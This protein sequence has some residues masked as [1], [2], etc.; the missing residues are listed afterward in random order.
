MGV[1]ILL[2]LIV[3]L[4]ASVPASAG[5]LVAETQHFRIYSQGSEKQL[6]ADAAVLEDYHQLLE[7]LTQRKFADDAPRLDIYLVR[8]GAALR[9]IVPEIGKQVAGFYHASDAGIAAFAASGS[10]PADWTP[11][12][13]I[14]LHEYAHHFMSQVGSAA[15]PAWYVEGFAEYLMTATFRPDRVEFGNY[16]KG[17][18][19]TLAAM[20]WISME[21]LLTRPPGVNIDAFYAQSWLLT[22]Y[23]FRAEGMAPRLKAYLARVTAGEDPV[24]AFKAEVANDLPGFQS[25]LRAYLNGNN[26]TY[27][28]MK[29]RPPEAARVTV[30]ALP[31]AADD[32]LLPLASLQLPQ[33]AAIDAVSL[34]LMKKA[35]A[36]AESDPWVGRALA[37]GEAIAGDR[38]AAAAG[39]DAHLARQ[40]DDPIA[41]RWRAS[42]YRASD[43]DTPRADVL[44][45][46]RLLARAFKAAPNDW[47]VLY[48]YARTYL[49][50][51]G[52]L[53]ANVVDVLAQA[54]RLAPQVSGLGMM[55]GMALAQDGFYSAAYAAMAPFVFNPHGRAAPPVLRDFL[56][57]LR[58]GD[59]ARVDAALV[60]LKAAP[61]PAETAVEVPPIPAPEAETTDVVDQSR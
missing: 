61:E 14:L 48:A 46:R 56:A 10:G 4:L 50:Q 6:R 20:P 31:P 49:S 42:L 3:A 40:P 51:P 13:Q 55:A 38:K 47:Q 58:G 59:K 34:A 18:A 5:W 16:N 60:A 21:A 7:L 36:G 1:R 17:R 24:A 9:T 41:L 32:M 2:L 39:L 26:L 35:A 33:Q 54:N 28:R 52:K 23:M 57:S 45:A 53:S 44:A 8:N 25:K 29:R 15:L 19:Y 22:H 12:R 37:I 27:S 30:S 43:P 11:G